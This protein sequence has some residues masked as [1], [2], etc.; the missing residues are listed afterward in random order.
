MPKL[1]FPSGETRTYEFQLVKPGK[2]VSFALVTLQSIHSHVSPEEKIL[3]LSFFGVHDFARQFP[4]TQFLICSFAFLALAVVNINGFRIRSLWAAGNGM[5]G[6]RLSVSIRMKFV[7]SRSRFGG[8][9]AKRLRRNPSK[10]VE[11]PKTNCG[12]T[13]K[14]TRNAS[15]YFFGGICGQ[16]LFFRHFSSRLR[17]FA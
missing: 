6:L 12:K 16:M 8:D 15:K 10:P 7:W 9:A 3:V 17:N 1:H 13:E 14:R 5:V 2:L 4:R 11:I